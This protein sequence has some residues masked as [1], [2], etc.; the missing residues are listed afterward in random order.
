[1][2]GPKIKDVNHGL[3]FGQRAHA[4]DRY[5]PGYPDEVIQVCVAAA[6]EGRRVLDVGA[7]TGKLSV[8]LAQAGLDVTAVD[9]DTDAL[10]LNPCPHVVG[11]AEELPFGS[12]SFDVVTVAQAWHWLDGQ[13]VAH[14]CARV[15]KPGGVVVIVVNQLDVSYP[16]V[17][18]IARITHAGD[19]YREDWRP[20]LGERF[21][22]VEARVFR[23]HQRATFDDIVGLASTR[24]YWLRHGD[25][26]RTRIV[27]HLRDYLYREISMGEYLDVPYTCLVYTARLR[28]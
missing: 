24:S 19:V 2:T 28:G 9:P 22:P 3:N 20:Q 14:E 26:D 1:M 15:L 27:G 5:R 10:A 25:S 7:G 11:Y 12:G 6:G 18:R 4:Y 8:A 21:E 17:M 23:F 13:A 16:W